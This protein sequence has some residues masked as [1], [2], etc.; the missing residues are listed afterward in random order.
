MQGA[1]LRA[2]EF[3]SLAIQ[4]RVAQKGVLVGAVHLC[5]STLEPFWEKKGMDGKI[6]YLVRHHI[7]INLGR[8]RW[9]QLVPAVLVN[10][11]VREDNVR[12]LLDVHVE[13]AH[14]LALIKPLRNLV[15]QE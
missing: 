7:K 15:N 5:V 9:A 2:K 8:T 12:E 11:L 14:R 10:C 4:S 1:L 6:T 3:V 13:I